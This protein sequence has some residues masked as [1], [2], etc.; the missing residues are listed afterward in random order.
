[1]NKLIVGY[2]S[3]ALAAV[4]A[5]GHAETASAGGLTRQEVRA[6]IRKEVAKIPRVRGPRGAEGRPGS[7]GPV[8]PA[9]PPGS[10]GPPGVNAPTPR[11]AHI[12]TDGTVDTL[13][14]SGIVQDNVIAFV[15]VNDPNSFK[16]YCFSGLDGVNGAQVT[17]DR[18][19]SATIKASA[20]VDLQVDDAC[21]QVIHIKDGNNREALARVTIYL[22]NPIQDGIVSGWTRQLYHLR[23]W[24]M[25]SATSPIPTY[26]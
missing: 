9:G 3:I 24:S 23:P 4:L 26:A 7:V 8:G 12:L 1:M 20:E 17:I 2:A 14:S 19:G 22:T 25:Q 13:K 21:T 18:V 5:A 6:L 15:D 11:F 10:Q 16:A